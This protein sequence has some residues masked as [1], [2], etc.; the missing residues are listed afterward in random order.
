VIIADTSGLLALFNRTE[1][2]HQEV[3]RVVEDSAEP[4]VVS[5]YVVAELDYLVATRI[6]VDAERSMLDELASGAYDVT[7]LDADGLAQASTVIARYRDQAIGVADA[8]L[9]VLAD[10]YHTR[11]LLTLDHRHFDV[12]RPLSGGRFKLLP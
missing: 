4:L 10:R 8:S 9:V 1:P 5:P 6:G 2:A 11:E 7:D 12:L 3:Q